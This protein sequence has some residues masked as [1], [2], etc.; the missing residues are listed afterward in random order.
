[1]TLC[2][3]K[4]CFR[5]CGCSQVD[6]DVPRHVHRE[7]DGEEHDV[8]VS[9]RTTPGERGG[10]PPVHVRLVRLST[11]GLRPPLAKNANTHSGTNSSTSEIGPFV[12]NPSPDATAAASHH[13]SFSC[14]FAPPRTRTA[15][16]P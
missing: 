14:P 16:T 4:K 15:P 1:M 2:S 9:E 10:E 7:H 5:N 12:R 3:Q 13:P 6:R 8:P 11:G